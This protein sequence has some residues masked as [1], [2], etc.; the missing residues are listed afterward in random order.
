MAKLKGEVTRIELIGMLNA[1]GIECPVGS[2][3]MYARDSGIL[4]RARKE[5][6]HGRWTL[7]FPSDSPDAMLRHISDRPSRVSKAAKDGK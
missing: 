6:V 7:Y 3:R 4:Q 5:M 2:F 1:L